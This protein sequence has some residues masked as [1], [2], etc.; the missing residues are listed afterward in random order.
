VEIMVAL[1]LITVLTLGG[2]SF[3][4]HSSQGV[5]QQRNKRVAIEVAN[6]RMERVLADAYKWSDEIDSA[7][8]YLAYDAQNTTFN[9]STSDPGE[10]V[11]V[12]G[13]DRAM[14]T[15]VR[16]VD[17]ATGSFTTAQC[18]EIDVQLAFMPSSSETVRL[19][20]LYRN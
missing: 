9:R 14:I 4:V 6:R 19:R 13:V 10:T 5:A 7:W 16:E 12:N 20:S 17:T 11:A 3:M 8:V 18:L 1:L 2:A 15:R